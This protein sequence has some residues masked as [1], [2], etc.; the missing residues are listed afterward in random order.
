MNCTS[1]RWKKPTKVT[2]QLSFEML[3][4][5][6]QWRIFQEEIKAQHPDPEEQQR[7][8]P[9]VKGWFK[10]RGFDIE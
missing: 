5:E 1:R 9:I 7:L 4:M 10:S 3:D 2:N 6:A 8:L